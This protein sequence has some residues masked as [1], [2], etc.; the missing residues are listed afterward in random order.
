VPEETQENLQEAILL[1]VRPKFDKLQFSVIEL[2][3]LENTIY[4]DQNDL[5][6]V[7]Y[8]K[9]IHEYLRDMEV[10]FV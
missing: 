8:S 1:P 3:L 4:K 10:I 2:S 5:G 6:S 7:E 9:D